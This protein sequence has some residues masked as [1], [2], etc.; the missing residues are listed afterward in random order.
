M[1]A[2]ED[3]GLGLKRPAT[4]LFKIVEKLFMVIREVD[5]GLRLATILPI[6]QV[7]MVHCW[8][9]MSLLVLFTTVFIMVNRW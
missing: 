3:V 2:I 4:I 6:T 7:T 8:V 5:I 9:Y 1:V